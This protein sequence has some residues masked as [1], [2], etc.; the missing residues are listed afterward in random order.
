MVYYYH[1]HQSSQSPHFIIIHPHVRRHCLIICKCDDHN[2]LKPLLTIVPGHVLGVLWF[3]QVPGDVV[4][5]Q[6]SVANRPYEILT[7]H[8]FPVVLLE[9]PI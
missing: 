7:K 4:Y 3:L 6:D 5:G 2:R 9:D 1:I 8:R